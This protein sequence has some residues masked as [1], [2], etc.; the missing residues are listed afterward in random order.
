MAWLRHVYQILLLV[1]VLK[2]VT[3]LSVTVELSPRRKDVVF[4]GDPAKLALELTTTVQ[5]GATGNLGTVQAIV[6]DAWGNAT[7]PA[8]DCEI[9]LR[10]TAIGT[11]ES[12]RSAK[13]AARGSNRAKTRDGVAA[14]HEVSLKADADGEFTLAAY[15][16]SRAVVHMSYFASRKH[17]IIILH[18]SVQLASARAEFHDLSHLH[19]MNQ[20][21]MLVCHARMQ[22][23]RAT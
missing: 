7:L 10:T 16:K 21:H 20:S 23:G 1:S 18:Q 2:A 12:G 19:L 11:D 22:S 4:A 9:T 5:Q 15:C 14:F 17:V 3:S 13:V 6:T 8:K